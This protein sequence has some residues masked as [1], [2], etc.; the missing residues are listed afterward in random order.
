MKEYRLKHVYIHLFHLYEIQEQARVFWMTE[1]RIV[2]ILG[3]GVL[4]D[5]KT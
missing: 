1:V 5:K 3:K 2:V 4:T